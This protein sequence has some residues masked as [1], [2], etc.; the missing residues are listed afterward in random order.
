MQK[1][2]IF[3]W[4][5]IGVKLFFEVTKEKWERKVE[6]RE[7]GY[8]EI[9]TFK[10][11]SESHFLFPAYVMINKINKMLYGK[12]D[13][14]VLHSLMFKELYNVHPLFDF[15]CYFFYLLLISNLFFRCHISLYLVTLWTLQLSWNLHQILWGYKCLIWPRLYNNWTTNKELLI[16]LTNTNLGSDFYSRSFDC[17]TLFWKS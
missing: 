17:T 13:I 11:L 5:R 2:L 10:C 7:R 14:V 16:N 8:G 1:I 4:R 15:L 3:C 6:K 9:F 12:Q